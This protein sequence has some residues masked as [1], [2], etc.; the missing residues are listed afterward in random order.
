MAGG[1]RQAR[2][3]ARDNARENELQ[4]AVPGGRVYAVDK[5]RL[6][7]FWQSIGLSRIELEEQQGSAYLWQGGYV[8]S[9]YFG[10]Q[11]V[12]GGEGDTPKE[13]L[14]CLRRIVRLLRKH[15]QL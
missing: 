12:A 6:K 7:D 2:K 13:A 4:V 15:G 3:V 5:D 8:A 11:W 10:G 1:D 9:W 14:A